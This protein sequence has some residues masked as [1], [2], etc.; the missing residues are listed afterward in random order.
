MNGIYDNIVMVYDFVIANAVFFLILLCGLLLIAL[1]LNVGRKREMKAEI[2]RQDER[3]NELLTDSK[4]LAAEAASAQENARAVREQAESLVAAAQQRAEE[5]EESMAAR[6]AEAVAIAEERLTKANDE[7]E[8]IL[9]AAENQAS[10]II[11]DAKAD[12][13][14]AQRDYEQTQRNTAKALE[15]TRK[16]LAEL[17]SSAAHHLAHGILTAGD[18]VPAVVEVKPGLQLE[19]PHDERHT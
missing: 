19:A 3:L 18:D 2:K 1:L 17:V 6:E 5:I 15:D 13:A 9:T 7:A 11:A 8:D 16:K 14:K 4:I 12:A 10:Q